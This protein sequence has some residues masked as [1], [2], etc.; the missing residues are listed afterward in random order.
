MW[1]TEAKSEVTVDE[2]GDWILSEE[3]VTVLKLPLL[4]TAAKKDILR[5]ELG[6]MLVVRVTP[7]EPARVREYK[8]QVR[9]GL[10]KSSSLLVGV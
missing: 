9:V 6:L 10:V 7:E 5:A 3:V 8:G 2:A 1:Q 4:S